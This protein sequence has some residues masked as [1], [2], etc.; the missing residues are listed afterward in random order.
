MEIC[1][2]QKLIFLFDK[3]KTEKYSVINQYMN[4]PIQIIE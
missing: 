4:Q 3:I 2:Q 1:V